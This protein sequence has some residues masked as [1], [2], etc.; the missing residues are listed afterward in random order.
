MKFRYSYPPTYDCR[1]AVHQ[2]GNSPRST[3]HDLGPMSDD[4]KITTTVCGIQLGDMS[5]PNTFSIIEWRLLERKQITPC[6]R[7]WNVGR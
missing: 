5:W 7:C 2:S 1:V 4:K 3:V 6:K